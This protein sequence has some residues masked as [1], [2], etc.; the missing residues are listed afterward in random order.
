M[1][2]KLRRFVNVVGSLGYN[3]K[4]N[5]I[6]RVRAMKKIII[7]SHRSLLFTG[8]VMLC[9]LLTVLPWS[10]ASAVGDWSYPNTEIEREKRENI[11]EGQLIEQESNY[12][13]QYEL[14]TIKKRCFAGVAG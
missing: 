4:V 10:E 5:G 14:V 2:A 3:L 8:I 7:P 11:L 6:R 12:Q 9:G 13:A 1:K